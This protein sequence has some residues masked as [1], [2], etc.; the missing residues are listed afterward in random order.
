MKTVFKKWKRKMKTE[1]KNVNQTHPY[2][3]SPLNIKG[4]C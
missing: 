2:I 1:N 4:S 3:L